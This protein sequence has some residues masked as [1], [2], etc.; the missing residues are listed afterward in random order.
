[1]ALRYLPHASRLLLVLALVGAG[2]WINGMRGTIK[3][4]ELQLEHKEEEIALL[5]AQVLDLTESYKK[6]L[7]RQQT[8]EEQTKKLKEDLAKARSR[9]RT[10]TIPS[11]CSGAVEW[12]RN[13]VSR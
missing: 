2:W 10:V 9:V 13:E 4:Q 3:E 8:A 12:L 7:A 11:D 6:L 5:R 1:M